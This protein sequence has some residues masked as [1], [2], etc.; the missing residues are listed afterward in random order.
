MLAEFD[1]CTDRSGKALRPAVC[2][3]QP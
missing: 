3:S 1:L 2:C